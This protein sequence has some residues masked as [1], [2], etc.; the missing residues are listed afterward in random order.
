MDFEILQ[1]LLHIINNYK[2]NHILIFSKKKLLNV[3]TLETIILGYFG[4]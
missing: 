2:V 4:V 3:I 1:F